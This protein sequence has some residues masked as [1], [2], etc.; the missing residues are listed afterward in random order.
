MQAIGAGCTP[1]IS[2]LNVG[3]GMSS[4]L[5]DSTDKKGRD[6]LHLAP[7]FL[8]CHLCSTPGDT[9]VHG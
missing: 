8:T 9:T 3:M 6:C 5:L 7:Y 1:A 2:L 4:I